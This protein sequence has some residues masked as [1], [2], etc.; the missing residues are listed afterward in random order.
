MASGTIPLKDPNFTLQMGKRDPEKKEEFPTPPSELETAGGL[1]PLGSFLS[2]L[3]ARN[4][5]VA[6]A[7]N[8][9][10]SSSLG[11]F[12]GAGQIGALR[13]QQSPSVDPLPPQTPRRA[14]DQLAMCRCP[15]EAPPA[16]PKVP[17]RPGLE[18]Q[19]P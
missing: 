3:A 12:S 16:A 13:T 14:R 5:S 11:N 19:A 1:L 15:R 7:L 2:Y 6:C 10:S 8:L 4:A 17:S 9:A 18:L